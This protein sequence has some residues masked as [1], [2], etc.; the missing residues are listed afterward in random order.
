MARRTKHTKAPEYL[1]LPEAAE[2][3]G[4]SLADLAGFIRDAGLDPTG[5]AEEWRLE[6]AEVEALKAERHMIGQ[7]N[8]AQLEKASSRLDKHG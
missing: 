5:P 8:Q 6:A 7:Q 4:V 1:T 3:I 2:E